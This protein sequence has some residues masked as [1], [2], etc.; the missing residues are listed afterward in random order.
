MPC[1]YTSVNPR[2]ICF[3]NDLSPDRYRTII[4][5]DGGILLIE[6]YWNLNWETAIF[7]KE[8]A[9]KRSSAKWW[10]FYLDLDVLTNFSFVRGEND[11]TENRTR[12]A[13][14]TRNSSIDFHFYPQVKLMVSDYS[15]LGLI[16]PWR[17][18]VTCCE[19]GPPSIATVHFSKFS[20]ATNILFN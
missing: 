12:K 6:L 2:I 1:R 18:T 8:I 3:D 19:H 9:L 17:V 16:L 11:T 14:L 13:F 5:I 15:T 7:I 20:I 10:P 4:A